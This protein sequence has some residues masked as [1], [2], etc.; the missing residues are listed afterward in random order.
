MNLTGAR[1][2]HRP[3]ILAWLVLLA[4]LAVFGCSENPEEPRFD[5]PFDP[6]NPE[7]PFNLIAVVVDNA[8]LLSWTHPAGYDIV[9]YDVMRSSDGLFYEPLATIDAPTSASG[10]FTDENPIP[11]GTSYYKLV[12]RNSQQEQ[13][14]VSQV[15]AATVDVPLLVRVAD[16]GETTRTR[17]ARVRVRATGFEVA[18]ISQTDDFAAAQTVAFVGDSAVV[19]AWDLGPA[20]ANG[21]TLRVHACALQT[22]M[23]DGTPVTVSTDTSTV[24]VIVSFRPTLDLPAGVTTVPDLIVDLAVGGGPTGMTRLRLAP[25]RAELAAAP[26]LPPAAIVEDYVLRDT[27]QPQLVFAQF[28]SEFSPAF[29]VVDSQLVTPDLLTTV[30]FALDLPSN[31]VISDPSV[32]VLSA[33]VATQMRIS[34]DPGFRNA[35]W[36]AY[37]DTATV[38]V[39]AEP[40]FHVV[41][42]QYRNHW[43]QSAVQTDWA[44][45]SQDDV[46]IE[47]QDPVDG[48]VVRGGTF[49]E[50]RGRS[51]SS[52]SEAPVDSVKVN[53]GD[54]YVLATG[55]LEWSYGWDVPLLGADATRLLAA[56]AYTHRE[57]VVDSSTALITVTISQLA[58][59]ITA[60]AGGAQIIGGSEVAVAGT[61]VPFLGGAPLD[62]VV[63]IANNQRL[64]ATGL[65]NWSTP[66][67]A[68]TVTATTPLQ[69][70]ARAFAG[71][72]SAQTLVDVS[73][74]PAA[75]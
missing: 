4:V 59:A 42:A 54:G 16:G 15:A 41:Y 9:S 8:V 52:S 32:R 63:V 57:A 19:E 49:V 56:R 58:V 17:F 30:S 26:W 53:L 5:N 24:A 43:T 23:I 71:A 70:I 61:A 73:I 10:T 66:W 27:P 38:V 62:S 50:L 14:V 29:T 65:A 64:R 13:S 60:P 7:D 37:A 28:E 33:A 35:P 40:G 74:E 25:T 51:W 6:S 3:L 48:E 67:T 1:A 11:T 12:A 69:I 47:F 36:L 75:R 21:D 46:E 72:D 22:I 31:R 18:R 45:F 2:M 39:P 34:T 68:P 55:T 20:A 44:V